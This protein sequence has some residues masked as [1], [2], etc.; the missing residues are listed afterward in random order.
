VVEFAAAPEISLATF[1]LN[2]RG[3]CEAEVMTLVQAPIPEKKNQ[4]RRSSGPFLLKSLAFAYSLAV[5]LS[6]YLVVV[7][8][9]RALLF[10]VLG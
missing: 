2:G 1:D 8:L 5:R 4:A 9:A 10:V 7:L 3:V 6:G